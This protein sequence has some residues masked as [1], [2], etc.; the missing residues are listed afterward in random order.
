MSFLGNTL[1]ELSHTIAGELC[2]VHMTPLGEDS[3]KPMPGLSY[4]LLYV[5]FSIAN[6]NRYPLTLIHLNHDYS[7]FAELCGS[8]LQI[9]GPEGGLEDPCTQLYNKSP[10]VY[11]SL[12]LF[13]LHKLTHLL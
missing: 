3:W 9:I 12:L 2:A 1:C 4:T 7:G 8:F 10:Q 5:S 11:F 13:L 6:C